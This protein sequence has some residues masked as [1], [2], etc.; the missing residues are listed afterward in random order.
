MGIK[1]DLIES[2]CG[3]LSCDECNSQRIAAARALAELER[4]NIRLREALEK[5]VHLCF[6][7]AGVQSQTYA[8]IPGSTIIDSKPF[9][10]SH[11]TYASPTSELPPPPPEP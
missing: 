6:G 3:E 4:E 5:I 1:M 2:T 7:A 8:S 9:Q 10:V 11:S